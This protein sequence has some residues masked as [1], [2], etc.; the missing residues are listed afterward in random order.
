MLYD[1][2]ILHWRVFYNGINNQVVCVK[3]IKRNESWAVRN[4]H[5][6][7]SDEATLRLKWKEEQIGL[8]VEGVGEE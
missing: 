5:G 1:R 6:E 3:K 7:S 8:A 2:N 4:R